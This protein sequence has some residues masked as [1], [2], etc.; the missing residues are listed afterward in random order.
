MRTSE[1]AGSSSLHLLSSAKAPGW[2]KRTLR[3]ARKPGGALLSPG[4]T[5]AG[6]TSLTWR[7]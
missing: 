5:H 4:P 7:N 3:E 2:T 6:P 1:S